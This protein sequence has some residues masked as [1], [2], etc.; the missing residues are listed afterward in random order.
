[1]E[2]YRNDR[3]TTIELRWNRNAFRGFIASLLSMT[4]VFWVSQCIA[5][6]EAEVYIPV[7]ETGL[8]MISFGDGDGTGGSKG[9]LTEEGIK[10]KGAALSNQLDD[11]ET[12]QQSNRQTNQQQVEAANIRASN[13]GSH[14]STTNANGTRTTGANDGATN[15]T[16][17]GL[18]GEGRGLGT[19][20]YDISWGGGGNRRVTNKVVPKFPGTLDTEVKLKFRVAPDGKVVWALPVR[21]GGNPKVDEEARNALLRWRFNPLGSAQEMEGVITFKFKNS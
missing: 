9:N 6:P 7:R 19:G 18:A 15:G 12:A 4:L 8:V 3:E 20:L 10:Q 11:A 14:N 2:R 21:R 16:G 5:P 1:M 17:L 13:A